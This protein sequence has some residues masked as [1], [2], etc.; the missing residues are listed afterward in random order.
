DPE[1]VGELLGYF[2]APL[3]TGLAE[4]IEEHPLRREILATR[5]ANRVVSRAGIT[6]VER[7]R[8]ELGADPAAIARAHGAAWAVHDMEHHWRAIEG[9]EPRVGPPGPTGMRPRGAPPRVRR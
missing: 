6:F 7:H 3:R 9:M 8:E 5:L 4:R 2:P 1:L